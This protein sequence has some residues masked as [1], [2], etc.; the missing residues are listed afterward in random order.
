MRAAPHTFPDREPVRNDIGPV[1]SSQ[2]IKGTT[3]FDALTYGSGGLP[4]PTEKTALT[5]SA[6]YASVNLIAGAISTL[7]LNIYRRD[8]NGELDQLHDDPLWWVFNEQMVPRWS[9]ANGWEFLV[10]SLLLPGDAFA[11]LKRT[12]NG[13]V[14]GIEPVLYN[15][16][17]PLPSQDGSRLLYAIEPDF[18][19]PERYRGEREVLDQDDVL[20]VPGFGFDGYRGM[21]PLRYALRMTGA[22]ALATQEFAARFFANSAR[23]DLVFQ[24]DRTLTNEV[25]DKL[26]EQWA[27]RHQGVSNAHKPAILTNG[28]EAK[29]LSIPMEDLQLLQLRQFQ[30]EEVARIYGVPPFMIGHNE[31]TTSW[32]SGVEAMGVGFVRYTLRQHLNKFENEF[33]RKIFRTASKVAAFDTADLERADLKSLFEAY[34]TALGRAGEPGF[35]TVEEV[36]D[37]IK[38]KRQPDTPLPTGG[39]NAPEQASQPAG[40]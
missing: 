34:R 20:H 18:G 40:G 14:I 16:V 26:R 22:E 13:E 19:L 12:R 7:P 6:I 8:R 17:T 27:E 39:T 32:G 4:V 37:K 24:T 9:A 10:Q 29:V 5:V 3:L 23:P 28:L 1:D 35:M 31:K 21:S 36:R 2:I 15:R 11:K 33:N 38:L 25:V 30:V